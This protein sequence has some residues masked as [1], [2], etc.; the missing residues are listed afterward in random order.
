M[1]HPWRCSLYAL[2]FS[3]ALWAAIGL[4]AYCVWKDMQ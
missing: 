3:T 1:T 2:T 4:V